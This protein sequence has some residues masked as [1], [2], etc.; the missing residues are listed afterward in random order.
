MSIKL[1]G[2][3]LIVA[4]CGGVGF[5][6]AAAHR[7][8]ENGLRQLIGALDYMGCEL[9]YHLTPLPE[10]CRGAAEQAGG[11]I[12][13]VLLGL[14]AELENQIAPDAA[15]CMNAAISKASKLP[16][17]VRKNLTLLGGSLGRF[18]LDGQ[19]KGLEAAR[20][21]CR[22]DFDELSRDRDVRLR[23][24]QTL[25]LCAGAALAILFL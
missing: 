3:A 8:E 16:H 21:Q 13:S 6:M 18:E 25:G 11:C 9:Q 22:R 4:G 5:S 20:Q 17:Q 24:Y 14:A 12:R 19:L 2:A 1:I 23:S 15:S 7:R 10:L